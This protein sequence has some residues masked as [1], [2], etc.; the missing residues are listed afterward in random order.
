MLW[1]NALLTGYFAYNGTIYTVESLGGGVNAF[2]EMDRRLIPADHPAEGGR[3]DS[4]PV[5]PA[6]KPASLVPIAEPNIN[7]FVDAHRIR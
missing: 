7:Q 4:V 6:P 2:S 1:S 3:A 5:T